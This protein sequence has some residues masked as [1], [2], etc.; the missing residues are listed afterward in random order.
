[1]TEFWEEAF[2]DKQ[3][4]WGLEPAKAAVLT[5]DFF[6]AN[7][8]KNILVPGIGYGRNA[9]IF[10]DSGITVT[11]IEISKTAI[12]IAKKHFGDN[13]TI[14]HGSVTE[15]PFDNKLYDGIFCYA[16]IHL[17]DENERIKLI[18]DCYK[19]LAENGY[20]VFTTVTKKA[21]TYEQG[22]CISKDR[23]EMFGGVKIFFYDKETIQK[24]FCK[25]GLLEVS[26]IDEHFPFYLIKCKRM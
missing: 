19:Q 15:M 5:K 18:T 9:Q 13:L 11:G 8:L 12:D 4:M 3:E 7:G 14:Y 6:I 16:L 23:F 10:R 22:T 17:L 1:M 2:K 20:M 21:H 25:A 26:E 24:E